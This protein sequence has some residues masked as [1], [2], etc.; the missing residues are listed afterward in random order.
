MNRLFKYSNAVHSEERILELTDVL[1]FGVG[2]FNI[3]KILGYNGFG[4]LYI[5]LL[6]TDVVSGRPN[7]KMRVFV[8]VGPFLLSEVNSIKHLK[9]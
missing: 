6:F 9:I 2:K 4:A 8:L 5:C 7:S 1:S 3:A